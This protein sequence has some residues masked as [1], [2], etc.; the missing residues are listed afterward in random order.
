MSSR[1]D[2]QSNVLV[3]V[4]VKSCFLFVA[5]WNYLFW[6]NWASFVFV[7]LSSFFIN[8]WYGS[9][10]NIETAQCCLF[11]HIRRNNIIFR[12]VNIKTISQK[13]PIIYPKNW[14]GLFYYHFQLMCLN[15]ARWVANS[16]NPDQT[17]RF[18][19]SDLSLH[20]LLRPVYSNG[21]IWV[22]DML[23]AHL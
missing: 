1:S 15:T 13:Y 11:S 19:A 23:I 6:I 14:T 9:R 10:L 4:E 8:N 22:Y 5:W 21:V 16:V 7:Q 2:S 12:D 20:C 18:T 17:P 3:S